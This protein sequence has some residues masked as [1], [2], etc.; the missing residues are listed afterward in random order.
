MRNALFTLRCANE[1]FVSARRLDWHAKG[2]S[3]PE[4]AVPL[5]LS[6]LLSLDF[7]GQ[8][9][10]PL[11]DGSDFGDEDG[12]LPSN[13]SVGVIGTAVEGEAGV[14]EDVIGAWGKENGC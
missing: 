7:Y 1:K 4:S 9:P 5:S 2:V 6:G 3:S 10:K 11:F 14:D 8:V 12:F 13:S